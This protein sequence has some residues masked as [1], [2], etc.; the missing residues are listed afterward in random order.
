METNITVRTDGAALG[1]WTQDV[2]AARAL[3]KEKGKYLFMNF[4]GSDWC[5]WCQLMEEH[6]F[7]Q[8]GWKA[9]AEEHLALAFID[10]PRDA[11]RVPEKYRAR[12]RDA[13]S[14]RAGC[15]TRLR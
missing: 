7:S 15:R 2:E 1:E 5:G 12:N 8:P 11:A 9:F 13:K 14:A 4:T 10:F 3:A 6:V